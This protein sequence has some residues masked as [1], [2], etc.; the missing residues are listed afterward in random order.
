MGMVGR[1]KGEEH[2][3]EA[4]AAKKKGKHAKITRLDE[5]YR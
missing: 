1:E 5:Q 4:D 2:K 3:Q